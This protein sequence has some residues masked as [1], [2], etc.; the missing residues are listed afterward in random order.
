LGD[1]NIG[2]IAGSL[3]PVTALSLGGLVPLAYATL[4]AARRGQVSR[5]QVPAHA[6]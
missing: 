6:Q 1:L 3:G 5:Y 2:W 4:L